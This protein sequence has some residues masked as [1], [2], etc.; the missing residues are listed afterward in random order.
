MSKLPE[1]LIC[2]NANRH[3]LSL[4]FASSLALLLLLTIGQHFWQSAKLPLIFLVLSSLVTLVIGVVKLIEP[5]F[6]FKLTPKSLTFIHRK[7]IWS[8]PWSVIRNVRP[9]KNVSGIDME[10]LDY[11]GIAI[12]NINEIASR[13]PPRLANHLIHEQRPIL[14]YCVSR[15]LL[16]IEEIVINFDVFI[17]GQNKLKGP[18]AG[19]LHQ[20]ALL[21]GIFGAHLFIPN[22]CIDRSMEEFSK[23]LRECKKY[24]Q[25]Y[26]N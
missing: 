4:T 18:I 5:Q 14:L 24:H 7:G 25:H 26:L 20:C 2:S 10:E 15:N 3:G 12:T 6:S 22:T 21:H 13:I 8:L 9:V 23:L 11:I 19:F 1:I 17:L 16:T